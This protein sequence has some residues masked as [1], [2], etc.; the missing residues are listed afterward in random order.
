MQGFTDVALLTVTM[1]AALAG[2][3]T[4]PGAEATA[5]PGATTPFA[6]RGNEPGWSL[7]IRGDRLLLNLDYGTRTVEAA[8]PER[9]IED[10]AAVYAIDEKGIRISITEELCKDDMTGMPYPASLSLEVAGET[11]DRVL[12]GCGGEPRSL[13]EGPEWRVEGIAGEPVPEDIEV[14]IGFLEED[15]IAGSGGCN[16]FM[17][18]YTLTGEGLSIGQVASTM[19]ACPEPAMAVEQRFLRLLE[20]VARFDISPDGALI[21]ETNDGRS[22]RARR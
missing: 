8:L 9:Q 2:T 19:M 18:G 6:A 5:P 21:L 22:A 13:L 4:I 1:A 15:R 20:A 3:G 14:T 12:H 10:G 16:R 11:G 17:G 7:E